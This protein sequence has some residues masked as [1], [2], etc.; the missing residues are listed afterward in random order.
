MECSDKLKNAFI[1]VGAFSVERNFIHG[2]PEGVLKWIEGEVEA[3][4]EVLSGRGNFCACVGAQGAVSS[5]EI[6]GCDH[7]KVIIQPDFSVSVT[8]IKEPS[9]EASALSGKFYSEV[10]MNDDR[11]M[12][13][14][15]IRRNEKESHL[16][17]EEARK[18]EEAAGRERCIGVFVI[19]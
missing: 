3:F 8:D 11:E 10:W 18:A 14:K 2:D 1:S 7:A 6:V 13:D 9:T 5:L 4:D 16:A 12:A 15:A 19:F 17:S